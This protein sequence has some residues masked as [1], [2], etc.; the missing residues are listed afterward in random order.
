MLP[1]TW[2]KSCVK[3]MKMK[4]FLTNL[5]YRFP[6]TPLKSLQEPITLMLMLLISI[7]LKIVRSMSNLWRKEAEELVVL[8]HIEEKG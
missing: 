3:S 7:H 4:L 1:N 8:D 2:I 6:Q 5:T